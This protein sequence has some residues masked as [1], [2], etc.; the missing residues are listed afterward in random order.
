MSGAALGPAAQRAIAIGLWVAVV[1]AAGIWAVAQDVGPGEGASRLVDAIQGSAWGPFVF[2]AVYL[3]RP[4]FFFSAAALTV[5]GGFLFG[6][7]LGIALVVIAANGS[8][9]IAYGVARWLGSGYVA[10]AD[11][12]GRLARWTGR[13]RARSFETVLVMRLVYLPYDLVSYLAGAIRIHPGAFLAATA[14]G[15]APATVAFVLFGASLESFDG[16]VPRIDGTILAASAILLVLG[17]A[18]AQVLRRR[19]RGRDAD[20]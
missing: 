12:R 4:L 20:A 1:G 17:I 10:A 8:A 6:A 19:E 13:M 11:A 16:G 14:I 7:P 5:A 2:V 3:A 15:S 18:L 9:L